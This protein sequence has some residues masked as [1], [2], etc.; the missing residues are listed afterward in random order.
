MLHALTQVDAVS[1]EDFVELN[2]FLPRWQLTALGELAQRR[3][4]RIGPLLRRLLAEILSHG[5]DDAA[6][7]AVMPRTGRQQAELDSI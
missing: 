1:E 2:L 6:S 5:V 3:G 4:T 7:P